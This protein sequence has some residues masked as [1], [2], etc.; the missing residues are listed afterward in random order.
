MSRHK[1]KDWIRRE[2]KRPTESAIL[3]NLP[4][5]E[6]GITLADLMV[7]V[8]ASQGTIEAILS[9]LIAEGTIT[10][11]STRPALYRKGV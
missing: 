8:N 7:R 4:T 2:T 1:R 11:S 10:K 9:N 3:A 6:P 5:E